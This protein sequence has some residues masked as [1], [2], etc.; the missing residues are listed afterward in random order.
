M[1][2]KQVHFHGMLMERDFEA[3]LHVVTGV[4][5]RSA[6]AKAGVRPGSCIRLIDGVLVGGMNDEDLRK[7]IF[8]G[9]GEAV[10]FGLQPPKMTSVSYFQFKRRRFVDTY[11]YV[12]DD[13]GSGDDCSYCD[14]WSDKQHD[15]FE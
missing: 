9:Q 8:G 15:V 7:L 1:A 10:V 5:Q 14:G 4:L 13:A 11:Q 6:A 2:E 3:G 12:D